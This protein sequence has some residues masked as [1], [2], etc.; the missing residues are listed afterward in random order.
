[1]IFC[2]AH[3][4]ALNNFCRLNMSYYNYIPLVNFSLSCVSLDE[5]ISREIDE[6]DCHPG[7]S[8]R[9]RQGIIHQ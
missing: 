7:I 4:I 5:S 3:Y 9:G 6:T 2:M 8:A 1:M